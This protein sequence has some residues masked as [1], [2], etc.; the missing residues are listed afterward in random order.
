MSSRRATVLFCLLSFGCPPGDPKLDVPAAPPKANSAPAPP[1]RPAPN[2]G[3]KPPLAPPPWHVPV[4]PTLSI[5]PGK[6]LGPIR[7]GAQVETIERLMGQPCAE[8]QDQ[9]EGVVACRYSAHAVEFF[10]GSRGLERIRVH[11]LGRPFRPGQEKPDFGIFNG[12]FGSGLSV[13]MLPN[14]VK[15]LAGAPKSVRQVPAG[16]P[17]GTVEIHEYDGFSLE[18]DRTGP[19]RLVLGGVVLARPAS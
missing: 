10:V 7:F 3:R 9:G 1:N 2:A 4:G 14:A 11:R 16:D 5:E 6:G 15:E 18:L 8:K 13:G 12:R 19:D 17:F